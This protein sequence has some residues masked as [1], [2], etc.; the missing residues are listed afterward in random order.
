MSDFDFLKVLQHELITTLE[1][2][3]EVR[4]ISRDVSKAK[5]HR[6][7]LQIQE[8]MLRIEKACYSTYKNRPEAWE[9]VKLSEKD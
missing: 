4:V 3:K 9:N 6:L 8:V 2:R 7:R 5:I 1:N